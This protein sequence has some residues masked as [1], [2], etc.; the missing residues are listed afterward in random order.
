MP[1]PLPRAPTHRSEEEDEG[2]GGG[3]DL[4]TL[5]AMMVEV[6]LQGVHMHKGATLFSSWVGGSSAN[7]RSE[8]LTAHPPTWCADRPQAQAGHAAQAGGVQ[9]LCLPTRHVH[10][11]CHVA[12]ARQF[13]R[14]VLHV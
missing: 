5:Q 14:L 11:C 4:A 6:R 9:A 1:P 12:C 2:E 3:M 10:M 7:T 13:S 8:S